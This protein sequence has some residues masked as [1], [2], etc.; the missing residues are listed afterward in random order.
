MT[1][2]I[3]LGIDPGA[4]GAIAALADGAYYDVLDMPVT[5]GREENGRGHVDG[6][7]LADWLREMSRRNPGAAFDAVIEQVGARPGQ[8]VTSMFR[9]G[10]AYGTVRG[11]LGALGI[12]FRVVSPNLWKPRM[13]LVGPAKDSAREMAAHR[14]PAAATKL[15]RKKDHGRAEAL[16]IAKWAHE[17]EVAA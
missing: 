12:A 10:E 7:V 3:T 16:L 1:L 6:G 9:F 5:A 17:F 4:T 15:A 13:G 8:G 2:R 11:A 14:F